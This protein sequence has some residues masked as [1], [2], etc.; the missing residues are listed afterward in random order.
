MG[1]TAGGCR[2]DRVFALSRM[3][4]VDDRR[5]GL[6]WS[7]GAD[8]HAEADALLIA[9]LEAFVQDHRP[10]G[11]LVADAGTAGPNGYRL[12][13]VCHCGVSFERQVTPDDVGVELA[14]LA[15]WN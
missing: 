2:D 5:P 3:S 4:T 9:D 14:L 13:V 6:Y 10:H 15:R 1:R 11:D 8:S 12:T 7:H